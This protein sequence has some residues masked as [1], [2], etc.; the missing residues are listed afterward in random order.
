MRNT[1]SGTLT[2]LASG[3][4]TAPGTG[5]WQHLALTFDGD[6]ITAAINGTTV[7]TVTDTAY[8]AGMIGLGTDG[9]QTDQFGDLS[10]TPVGSAT[11][12][13]PDRRGRRLRRVR[14]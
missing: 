14:R 7:G 13:R 9:Y 2:T 8:P 11:L 10:V 3:T 5:T 6:S 4:V 12:D 1:T